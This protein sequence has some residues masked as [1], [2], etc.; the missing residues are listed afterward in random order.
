MNACAP[1]YSAYCS[2]EIPFTSP[3][4][5]PGITQE[6]RLHSKVP[7][8]LPDYLRASVAPC[9]SGNKSFRL[10]STRPQ[11]GVPL[12]GGFC[13]SYGF[14]VLLLSLRGILHAGFL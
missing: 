9:L 3:K 4:I 7:C 2:S 8:C 14:A 1:C 11:A 6:R 12:R 13:F 10:L 5:V